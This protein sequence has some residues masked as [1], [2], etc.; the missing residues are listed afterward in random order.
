[1]IDRT[2]I[3]QEATE[4]SEE[5]HAA[6]S[7]VVQA[8]AELAWMEE[9]RDVWPKKTS[10]VGAVSFRKVLPKGEESL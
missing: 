3:A 2:W 1:M 4:D 9:G 7:R 5:A 8:G 6:H 10:P